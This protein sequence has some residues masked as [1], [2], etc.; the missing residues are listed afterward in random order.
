M[1][2]LPEA[3]S[4]AGLQFTVATEEDF[5]DIMAM[6]QDIYGGLDYLPTRYT[7]WLQET[8][9]T[10]ILARKQGKVIALESVCV[11]DDGETM[12]VEGLR[13]APQERGKGVAGVLLRFCS[14]L[15]KAKF[16]DV[17]VARLTRDDQLGPKDFQKYRIITKQGILLLRFRAEDVKLR[18]SE[19][20]IA[21]DVQSPSST[22]SDA[23]PVR[24]DQT[25]IH[26]LYLSTDLM[27]G[28]LPNATIIQDWQPFKMLPSNMAILWKKDIDWM[29]DDVSNPTVASLCTFPFRVPIGDDW[30]YLNIDM[31]GKDLALARQQFLCHLLRHTATLKGHVMC[32]MFLDPPL[33]KPMADFCTQTLKVELVKEYTEQCVVESD[34]V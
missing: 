25:A 22:S 34:V 8:N 10:V 11:I 18:L 2:Q 21:G 4:Q 9:R 24:L 13:V 33:W 16:P 17:K 26:H 32:Q 7:S 19:L 5:D 14:E 27:K 3:L 6:S 12:L 30:Y 15:V 31:F 23:P 28:V 29:V 20:A 1:P